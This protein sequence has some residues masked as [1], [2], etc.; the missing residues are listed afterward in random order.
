VGGRSENRHL[1][2]IPPSTP[3]GGANKFPDA[4]GPRTTA[5]PLLLAL[6][7]IMASETL[8]SMALSPTWPPLSLANINVQVLVNECEEA[9]MNP[10]G[11]SQPF[12]AVTSVLSVP[13]YCEKLS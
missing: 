2:D 5:P 11:V 1:P 3:H 7:L 13:I 4:D 10:A 12:L 6:E 9:E 8:S